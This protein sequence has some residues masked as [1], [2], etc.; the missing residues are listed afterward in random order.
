M[1]NMLTACGR[2]AIRYRD[3]CLREQ[4][5]QN[6]DMAYAYIYCTT[7]YMYAPDAGQAESTLEARRG[8][9]MVYICICV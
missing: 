4:Q 9:N 7:V 8:T 5:H 1:R 6:P 2:G 3:L